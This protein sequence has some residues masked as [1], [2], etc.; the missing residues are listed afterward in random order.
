MKLNLKLVNR[1]VSGKLQG[2]A[3]EDVIKMWNRS[4]GKITL[5]FILHNYKRE[6]EQVTPTWRLFFHQV[7]SFLIWCTLSNIQFGLEN[8]TQDLLAGIAI[9]TMH[10]CHT[11]CFIETNIV[12]F[13]C[14]IHVWTLK[15]KQCIGIHI[16]YVIF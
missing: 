5:L 2:K 13:M 4:R 3:T 9:P 8:Q 1:F 16:C 11:V 12:F 15:K 7:W 14:G 6:S 10:V